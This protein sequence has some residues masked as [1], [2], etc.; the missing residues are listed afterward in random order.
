MGLFDALDK[1]MDD[2]ENGAMEKR[3]NQV[4]DKIEGTG[5]QAV[6]KVEKLAK[7]TENVVNKADRLA[8]RADKTIDGIQKKHR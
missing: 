2:I 3:V 8:K 1:L 7:N 4:L 5:S 6:N